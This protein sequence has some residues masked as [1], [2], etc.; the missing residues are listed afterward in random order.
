MAETSSSK[1]GW[2]DCPLWT[3]VVKEGEEKK[4]RALS[5]VTCFGCNKKG[6]IITHCPEK[7]KKEDKHEEEQD[8]MPNFGKEPE[9]SEESTIK[10]PPSGSLYT[11][12]ECG[13]LLANGGLDDTFHI[14]SGASD[15]T[16]PVEIS[17]AE[18]G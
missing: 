12:M 2:L 11:T 8:E 14:D 1:D 10:K 17:A 15:H 9:K 3:A 18:G 5:N 4:E 16:R 7:D 6:H 13:T